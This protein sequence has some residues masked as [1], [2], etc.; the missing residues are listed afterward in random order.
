MER[1]LVRRGL[2]RLIL[3]PILLSVLYAGLVLWQLQR[4]L[5]ERD[6]VQH[7]TG[8]ITLGTDVQRHFALQQSA[9]RG[10]LLSNDPKFRTE[11]QMEDSQVDVTLQRLHQL[12]HDNAQQSARLDSILQHYWTW[13][14]SAK[15][16]ISHD[17]SMNSQVAGVRDRGATMALV[18]QVFARFVSEEDLLYREREDR[19]QRVTVVLAI[20]IGALSILLGLIVG[21]YARRQANLFIRKFG[22]AI[23]ESS[24]SRDLLR[25]TLISIGD[26]IIVTDQFRTVTLINTRAEELTGWSI[27]EAT[28]RKIDDIF[29]IADELT[30]ESI[31]NPVLTVLKE[32]RPLEL[33]QH[34]VLLSRKGV[35]FPIEESAAPIRNSRRQI[36]GAALVFR[37]ISARR[38]SERDSEQ[39]SREFR[40]LI[41]NA[42]DVIIRYAKDLRITYVNPAIEYMLGIN[43]GALIGK[44]FK[45]V[46]I[47]EEVYF[48]WERAVHDVFAK[49]HSISTEIQ[50]QTLHGIRRYQ[51]RLV[52]ETSDSGIQS[53]I[54]ISRD[55]T[56][57]KQIEFRLRE[58][59]QRFRGIIE[60]NPNAFFLL[61]AIRDAQ[62]IIVDFRFE[63]MNARAGDLITL[64]PDQCVGKRLLEV[65]PGPSPEKYVQDYAAIVDM[66][67][68][69]LEEYRVNSAYLRRASWL[70]SQYVPI[71]DT[72]AISTE[73]ITELKQTED[74]LRQS[75]H[76]YRRLVDSA[77][78]AI[79]ST[80]ETGRFT[81]TN[82]FIRELSGYTAEEAMHFHFVDLVPEEHRSRVQRHFFRQF[83]SETPASFLEAPFVT[84]S[85]RKLWL[86]ITTSLRSGEGGIEGFD[87]IASDVTLHHDRE[88]ELEAAKTLAE[89][90]VQES[91][92]RTEQLKQQVV[93]VRELIREALAN[94][95]TSH[96]ELEVLLKRLD[97]LISGMA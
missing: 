35:E 29:R 18:R 47:P 36:M 69:K 63:Y 32:Q 61:T 31:E 45:D 75:E 42:P 2:N 20:T 23:D 82:P 71:G 48:P 57:I 8:V 95:R 12:V 46:G 68:P 28:G 34:T 56:E 3:L 4:M 13:Q 24:Q 21:L 33:R 77:Q 58:S 17:T 73:D 93:P 51:A 79:F 72:L 65:M 19:F 52:P 11:F 53:V 7:T 88:A 81:Y 67:A 9:L 96:A 38:E 41:E 78:E 59:E 39:R 44:R 74:A 70:R 5:D 62:Q 49:Q 43:P 54:S 50:Y 10:Y 76:R 84:K 40:A 22:E 80:D 92:D 86:S 60:N 30:R 97:T 15:Y 83:L 64:D 66:A 1:F 16:S 89:R 25:T 26:A 87:C 27:A 6:W 90:S 85:G 37:D 91:T 14:A 55:I 94:D